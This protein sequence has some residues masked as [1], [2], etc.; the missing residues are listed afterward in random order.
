MMTNLTTQLLN[1]ETGFIVSAELILVSTI[2][3][4]SLVVGLTETANAVN[5]ELEDVGSAFGS[6]NQTYRYSGLRTPK[7]KT[8]GSLFDDDRDNCD[9][10]NDIRPTEAEGEGFGGYYDRGSDY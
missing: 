5:Q 2:A 8:S 6:V 7:G 4:L 10:Q 9:S 3:V 1:D